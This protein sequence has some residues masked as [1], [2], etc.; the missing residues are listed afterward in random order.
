MLS[1]EL[2]SCY[3]VDNAIIFPNYTCSLYPFGYRHPTYEQP[4]L[5]DEEV[6]CRLAAS[7]AAPVIATIHM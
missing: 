5:A 7:R 1:T 6:D 4:G 3:Q 2:I